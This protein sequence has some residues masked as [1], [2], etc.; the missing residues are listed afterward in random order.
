MGTDPNASPKEIAQ[1]LKIAEVAHQ[2][3]I[4]FRSKLGFYAHRPLARAVKDETDS[5]VSDAELIADCAQEIM[6]A[7]FVELRS[8]EERGETDV[9]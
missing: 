5:H 8:C 4:D 2:G 9:A 3:L 7:V 1:G 6:N